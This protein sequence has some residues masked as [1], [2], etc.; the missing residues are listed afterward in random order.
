[1]PV[2]IICVYY[3]AVVMV[4]TFM[5]RSW[6]NMQEWAMRYEL[7]R[8]V[9]AVTI[10]LLCSVLYLSLGED[11]PIQHRGELSRYF[12]RPAFANKYS[13]IL[14]LGVLA[15]L[16]YWAAELLSVFRE[17]AK[18]HMREKKHGN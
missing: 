1:V 18:L 15:M 3:Y 17:K 4:V 11:I 13:F 7:W 5:T 12:E 14:M 16:S 9:A 6:E 10:V 2:F 8:L